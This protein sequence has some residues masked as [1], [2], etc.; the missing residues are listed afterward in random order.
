MTPPALNAGGRAR[1]RES[2]GWGGWRESGRERERERGKR[3]SAQ[4]TLQTHSPDPP[5]KPPTQTHRCFKAR[6]TPSSF[7]PTPQHTHST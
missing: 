5:P 4:H 7:T 1:S 6:T 2:A 3:V